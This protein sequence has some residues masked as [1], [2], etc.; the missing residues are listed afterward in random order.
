MVLCWQL[1]LLSFLMIATALVMWWQQNRT[2]NTQSCCSGCWHYSRTL[3]LN[4]YWVTHLENWCTTKVEPRGK[5]EESNTERTPRKCAAPSLLMCIACCT[6]D[7]SRHT[8][9]EPMRLGK[10]ENYWNYRSTIKKG[11]H[12]CSR[13][14]LCLQLH[15]CLLT[16]SIFATENIKITLGSRGVGFTSQLLFLTFLLM[17][18]RKQ[19]RNTPIKCIPLGQSGYRIL[20]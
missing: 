17:I 10:S 19:K 7:K 12:Q 1:L 6:V 18:H 8:K 9:K 14:K 16:H 15:Q 3:V 20:S 4:G 11:F 2:N 13:K 5:H